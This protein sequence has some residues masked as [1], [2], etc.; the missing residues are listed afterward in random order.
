MV[1]DML[2][3][4]SAMLLVLLL[5]GC[6]SVASRSAA[7]P[8]VLTP[9]DS[10]RIEE[11]TQMEKNYEVGRIR[12]SYVGDPV[13]RRKTYQA[14]VRSDLLAVP[15]MQIAIDSPSLH[16]TLFK[17]NEYPVKYQAH[18]EGQLWN[19][20]EVEQP[21]NSTRLGVLFDDNGA[22]Y[23][24]VLNG[25]AE[26]P[27]PFESKPINAQIDLKRVERVLERRMT[28]NF[29]IIFGG[30]S[31]NQINLAYREF[32]PNDVARTAFFQELTYPVDAETL[33]YRSI[34]IKLHGVNAESITYEVTEE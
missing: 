27:D 26:L 33:R 14:K 17:G 18:S 24:R 12:T 4:A 3:C 16:I 32:T 9:L 19:V 25:D 23:N 2:R 22:L 7:A 30:I 20:M 28:E 15:A 31:R 1:V 5:S 10:I 29:E 11:K 21:G 8:M 6:G 13:I 34:K